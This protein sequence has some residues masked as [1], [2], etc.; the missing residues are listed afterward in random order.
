MTFG[1][2]IVLFYIKLIFLIFVNDSSK[3]KLPWTS[4]SIGGLFGYYP[5]VGEILYY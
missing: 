3:I 2:D 4:D 5:V 1:V